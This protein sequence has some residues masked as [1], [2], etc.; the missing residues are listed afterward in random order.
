MAPP[1]ALG[2]NYLFSLDIEGAEILA[3]KIS[4]IKTSVEMS[5]HNIGRDAKGF[6]NQPT[7]G[8]R[9]PD[10]ITVEMPVTDDKTVSDWFKEV[11][12][13]GGK[14]AKATY[15]SCGMKFYD[16]EGSVMATYMLEDAFISSWKLSGSTVGDSSVMTETIELVGASLKRI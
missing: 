16:Q 1:T 9:K 14:G 12:P 4:G 15:K 3:S 13:K 11:M 6:Y 8:V 7:P 10:P 2:S 5:D